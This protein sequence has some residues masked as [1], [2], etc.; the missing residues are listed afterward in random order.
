MRPRARALMA[1]QALIEN[2]RRDIELNARNSGLTVFQA[3]DKLK[4][5]LLLAGSGVVPNTLLIDQKA[6]KFRLDLD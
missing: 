4:A 1:I 5:D 3:R 6:M 2:E